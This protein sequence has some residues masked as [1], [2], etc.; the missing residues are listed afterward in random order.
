MS[1][2]IIAPLSTPQTMTRAAWQAI[3]GAD[4]LFCKRPG[5]PAPHLCWKQ[6]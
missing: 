4:R 3:Q 6:G 5:I 1:K 2:L